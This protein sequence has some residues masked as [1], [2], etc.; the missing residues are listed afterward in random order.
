MVENQNR[1]VEIQEQIQDYKQ[2]LV[3]AEQN[4]QTA[5]RACRITDAKQLKIKIE[6]LHQ[7]IMELEQQ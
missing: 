6:Y 4:Y 1:L 2:K 3:L 7:Q 5:K